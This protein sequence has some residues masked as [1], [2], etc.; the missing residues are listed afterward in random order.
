MKITKKEV[1]ILL[2][3]VGV[4]ALVLSY[5]YLYQPMTEENEALEKKNSNLSTEITALRAKIAQESEMVEETLAYN[6][7]SIEILE[8]FPS[9]LKV[10]NEIMDIV[11]MESKVNVEIPSLSISDPAVVTIDVTGNS[12]SKSALEDTTD[13]GNGEL[14]TI[15]DL[16]SVTTTIAYNTTYDGMKEMI[17]DVVSSEN[18]RSVQ[19]F[20]ATFNSATGELTGTLS[21]DSYFIFGSY[22]DYLAPTVSDIDHGTENI[23]G[24]V[25]EESG[26]LEEGEEGEDGEDTDSSE[27]ESSFSDAS[28]AGDSDDAS[29]LAANEE[30]EN[31]TDAAA[32]VAEIAEATTEADAADSSADSSAD[33]DS[34]SDSSADAGT[35]TSDSSAD[36][37]D[38]DSADSSADSSS[39]SS[40]DSSDSSTDSS[41]DG[42]SAGSSDSSSTSSSSSGSGSASSA[43]TGDTFL[44]PAGFWEAVKALFYDLTTITVK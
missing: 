21:F 14:A 24:T 38:T 40:A 23:F 39:D 34:A 4:L 8:E 9:Y 44:T 36:S 35:G 22:K 12:S 26:L 20:S 10:E 28:S 11:S 30:N 27:T 2:I 16:Y 37:S 15:C 31:S 42:S 13:I 25:S 41:S 19:T 29:E 32:E 3:L 33:S 7:A 17:T 18:T 1:R 43:K 6:E 5:L